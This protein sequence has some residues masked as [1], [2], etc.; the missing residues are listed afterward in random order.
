MIQQK[1]EAQKIIPLL[2]Q[3]LV[4]LQ[5]MLEILQHEYHALQE[6]DLE[7]FDKAVEEKELQVRSLKELEKYFQPLIEMMGGTINKEFIDNFI[8]NMELGP[9]KDQFQSTW[10]EFLQALKSCDEQNR[11]NNRIIE[12]SRINIRQTLDILRGEASAPALYGAS[13]KE[14][15][16]DQ[17]NPL[18]V[19]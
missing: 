12:S 14:N 15:P 2:Q 11:I 18:A 3:Q 6:N 9:E 17:G 10:E 19:A 16:D 13:G 4:A 8:N 5:S 7:A 1:P